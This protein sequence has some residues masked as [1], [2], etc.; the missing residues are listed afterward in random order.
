LTV[1]FTAVLTFLVHCFLAHRIWRLSHRNWFLTIP[2]IILAILRLMS[3]ATTT[4]QMIR[5]HSFTAFKA[6]FRWL[7]T[8]GLALSSTVDIIITASLLFLLHESRTGTNRLNDVID[9]LIRYTFETGSLTCAGTIVTMICWLALSH[10]LV[11]MGLH[12]VISKLY[13]NSLLVTL[14]TR[15]IIRST[16]SSREA[17]VVHPIVHLNDRRL[18]DSPTTDLYSRDIAFDKY[19]SSRKLE[20]NV[21]KSVE[22]AVE[23]GC[24]PSIRETDEEPK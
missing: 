5:L 17:R 11:F 13:A 2:I 20:I 8:L 3:A 19:N 18:D 22:Q 16:H 4:G 23:E 15:Q 7:F 24:E 9:S 21:M 10:S 1:A 6:Q 12:F 14:N